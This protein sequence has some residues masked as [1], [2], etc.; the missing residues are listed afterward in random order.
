MIECCQPR[1]TVRDALQRRLPA[2]LELCGDE[3]IVRVTRRVT[4]LGKRCLIAGLLQLQLYD[5][6]LFTSLFHVPVLGLQRRLN[7]YR[8]ARSSSRPMEISTRLAP[9]VIQ[10]GRPNIWFGRSHRYTG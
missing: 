5:A 2:L 7:G 10:R 4:P 8:L 3:P 1:L 6:S 9:K